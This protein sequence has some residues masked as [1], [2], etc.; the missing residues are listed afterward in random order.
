[1]S[2]F[3]NNIPINASSAAAIILMALV[4]TIPLLSF[5]LCIGVK[6]FSFLA[7]VMHVKI[8]L[9]FALCSI[10]LI[11]LIFAIKKGGLSRTKWLIISAVLIP[12]YLLAMRTIVFSVMDG[13]VQEYLAGVSVSKTM[14]PK[15][16]S[17]GYCLQIDT[18]SF[19]LIAMRDKE[20]IVFFRG[21][22]PSILSEQ[23]LSSGLSTFEKCKS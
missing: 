17:Q 21:V 5:L 11:S 19:R 1:M 23:S 16:E 4:V 3:K 15:M 10:L 18:F 7:D 22:W 14:L 6:E 13:T 12:H 8:W 2:S 9:T 20:E